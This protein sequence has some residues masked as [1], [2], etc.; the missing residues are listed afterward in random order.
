MAAFPVAVVTKLIGFQQDPR[1][2]N[3]VIIQWEFQFL[4]CGP[5][6]LEEQGAVS[7]AATMTKSQIRTAINGAIIASAADKGFIMPASK[8]Y[9]VADIAG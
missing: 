6:P 9:T 7:V 1:N 3:N 8:I 4:F 5:D 2:A